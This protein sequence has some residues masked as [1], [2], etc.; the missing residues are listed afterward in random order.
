M[1]PFFF[2]L[3]YSKWFITP[4]FLQTSFSGKTVIVT[5][6]NS[7][8]GREA[9]RHIVRL[10]ASRVIIAG[11]NPDALEETRQDIIATTGSSPEVIDTWQLDLCSYESVVSFAKRASTE[12]SR[13]DIVLENAG[14]STTVFRMEEQDES[15]ITTNVV[16]TLLLGLLL[17][18]KLKD[19]AAKF[20][21]RPHISIVTSETHYFTTAASERKAHSEAKHRTVFEILSDPQTANMK[22]R[23]MVSELLEILAVREMIKSSAPP[24]YPVI[25]NL[26]NPGFCYSNLTRECPQL[27]MA[28]MRVLMHARSSEVG[29]RTLVHAASAGEET[30]GAYLSD[31]KLSPVA[32][33]VTREEGKEMQARVWEELSQKLEDISPGVTK[34]L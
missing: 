9:A 8:L 2:H 7:G 24:G 18:P 15:T 6:G 14:R 34:N 22:E 13:L 27:F 30:H 20:N 33:F 26:V 29:S 23:Y 12:L 4:P 17:L 11:R 3:V 32:D 25:I 19:T 16:S 10:G 28:T 5:G 21:T 31:C 1:A